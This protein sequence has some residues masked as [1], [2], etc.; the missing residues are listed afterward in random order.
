MHGTT[1]AFFCPRINLLKL[2]APVLAE[3]A[4]RA[5]GFR[6]VLVVPT[7]PLMRYD[8][9]NRRLAAALRLD[10]LR[11]EAGPDVDV[12]PVDSVARFLD[13]VTERRV[14]A[15][16]VVGLSLPV[17]VREGVLVPSRARGVRWCS[18]GYLYEEL[19]HVLAGGVGILDD[20]DVATTFS[21][22][23]LERLAALVV[24]HR[25]GPAERVRAF[26]PIGF[27]E[28]DQAAGFD[29]R[30]LRDRYELPQ[31]RPVIVLATAP[32]FETYRGPVGM[33]WLFYRSWYSGQAAARA[34]GR[35]WGRG[36][37]PMDYYAGYR[38]VMTALRRL[39]DRH[40][41]ILVGKTRDK[42]D[43]PRFVRRMTDRLLSD[44]AYAPFRTLEL[45]ALADFYV[46]VSSS[47]AFEAAFLGRPGRTL[48]PFPPELYE[49][50]LFFE[51]KRDFFY[52]APGIWNAPGFAEVT[53][54]YVREDWTRF[55]DWTERGSLPPQVDPGVRTSVV[56]RTMG[57]A[58]F[59]ASAR[60]LDL[61]ETAL[62]RE[63]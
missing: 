8:G 60:F 28:C 29:R 16:V 50:P 7:A 48:V 44:G 59:K 24:E 32:P 52:G 57:F 30:A 34:A 6:A 54:T 5:A 42:H 41:A 17:D 25:L 61:V 15:V 39:A 9:K 45:L 56:E 10:Q 21:E 11:A 27:V 23:V 3:L 2:Y 13:V 22:T 40:G 43:D 36:R 47:T 12:A 14:R 58:D 38:D 33:R 31:D 35:W 1:I 46:G 26:H 49:H 4:K 18:L 20:W 37:A 51:L 63:R 53:R 62:G 19:L 55:V